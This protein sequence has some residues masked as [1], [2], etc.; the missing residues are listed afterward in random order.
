LPPSLRRVGVPADA[1]PETLQLVRER[2]L[3][4]SPPRILSYNGTAP[5]R[6]WIKVIAVHLAIDQT[7]ASSSVSRANAAYAG[8]TSPAPIDAATL[9]AK[10][11]VKAHLELALREELTRLPAERRALLRRHLVDNESVDSIARAIGVH[12]V[13]VARWLWSS[14]EEI[15]ENLRRRFQNELGIL[16]PDFDSLVQLARSTISV[17]LQALLAT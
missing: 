7:R 9:L 10:A 5:L 13:T 3:I 8:E 11:Q 17:D 15:L 12:R 16:P 4:G 1:I 2:L 14:G 6:S